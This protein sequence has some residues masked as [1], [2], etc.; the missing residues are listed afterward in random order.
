MVIFTGKILRF[1][2]V[3]RIDWNRSGTVVKPL[4]FD[5]TEQNR[6][7]MKWFYNGSKHLLEP[8]NF[9]GA[10]NRFWDIVVPKTG[11]DI[12]SLKI[13]LCFFIK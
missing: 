8:R 10:Y 7:E 11:K 2:G 6:N 1:Q 12:E 5:R 3:L 9:T 4:Y 13:F